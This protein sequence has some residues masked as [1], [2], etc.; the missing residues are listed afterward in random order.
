LTKFWLVRK[1]C[2]N[3]GFFWFQGV[4]GELGVRKVLNNSSGVTIALR[5]KWFLDYFGDVKNA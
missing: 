1:R 3:A 2:L 5:L 4:A